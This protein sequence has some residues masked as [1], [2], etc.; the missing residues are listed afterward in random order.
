MYFPDRGCVRP[1]RH[2]YGYATGITIYF[3]LIGCRHCSELSRSY[4]Y[5]FIRIN[6]SFKNK[7]LKTKEEERHTTCQRIVLN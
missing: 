5:I 2:L 7:R 1:L 4:I 3:A 6:C